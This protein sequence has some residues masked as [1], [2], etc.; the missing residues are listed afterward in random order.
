MENIVF[1][2]DSKESIFSN[3]ECYYIY[4]IKNNEIVQDIKLTKSLISIDRSKKLV[5]FT[6]METEDHYILA[7]MYFYKIIK[8][9]LED[10]ASE[11]NNYTVV[12]N[13]TGGGI[14]YK[15]NK[16]V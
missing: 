6:G 4:D 16:E 5:Y 3:L 9:F 1:I 8:Q 2:Y 12:K 15:Y 7:K 13:C 11:C 14:Y 10:E